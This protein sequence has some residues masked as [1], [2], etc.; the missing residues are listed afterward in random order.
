M[1]ISLFHAAWLVR[2][3]GAGEGAGVAFAEKVALLAVASG[4]ALD[5]TVEELDVSCHSRDVC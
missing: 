2:G 3:F 4:R 1:L 5:G